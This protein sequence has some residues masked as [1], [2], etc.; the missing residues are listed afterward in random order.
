MQLSLEFL[1]VK[2]TNCK[3]LSLQYFSDGSEFHFFLSKMSIESISY[4]P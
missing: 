2:K 1:M 4:A 3:P